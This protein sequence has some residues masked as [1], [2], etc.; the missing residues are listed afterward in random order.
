[1]AQEL[2]DAYGVEP[3]IRMELST[4]EA[5]KQA[6]L[7]GLGV[8]ILSRYTLGLDVVQDQ[9]VALDVEGFPV[10]RHWHFVYPVGKQLPLV[11]QT[12]MEFA[13]KEAKNLVLDHVPGLKSRQPARRPEDGAL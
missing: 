3:R 6:I 5:I 2:F 1:V 13:R 9:L 8:S 4:N 11:A 12:F 10:E 7:A